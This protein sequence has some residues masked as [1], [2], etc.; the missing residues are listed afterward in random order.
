MQ[1]KELATE[2]SLVALSVWIL[3]LTAY[4]CVSAPWHSFLSSLRPDTNQLISEALKFH[5]VPVFLSRLPYVFYVLI[6]N[7]VALLTG[8]RILRLLKACPEFNSGS[9]DSKIERII[10]SIPL[11]WG[12]YSIGIFYLGI[13]GLLYKE[14]VYLFLTLLGILSI[15]EVKRFFEPHHPIHLPHG[16]SP[17]EADLGEIKVRGFKL[18]KTDLVFLPI[19]IIIIT[20]QFVISF[21]LTPSAVVY[22]M[23]LPKLYIKHHAL[24]H[25]PGFFHST[26]PAH[27]DMLYLLGLITSGETL[28]K[29]FSLSISLM[30]LIALLFVGT[31][32]FSKGAGYLAVVIMML[33]VPS[34]STLFSEPYVDI[35]FG[36]FSLLG[37][38]VFF[39]WVEKRRVRQ[40]HPERSRRDGYLYLAIIY[41]AL[42]AATKTPGLF[43]VLLFFAGFLVFVKK[44]RQFLK[45]LVRCILLMGIT[46]LPWYIRSWWLT[47]DPVF[48]S[49][50]NYLG[51]RYWNEYS[52]N[53]FW[54]YLSL[55]EFGGVKGFSDFI[56]INKALFSSS[57]QDI[58]NSLSP[59]II[60]FLMPALITLRN[61]NR[62][63][64]YFFFITLGYYIFFIFTS[65]QSRFFY[66]GLAILGIIVAHFIKTV[67][68][69]YSLIRIPIIL[70]IVA[71]SI[72]SF[73]ASVKWNE[74]SFF[75]G[76]GVLDQRR[77]LNESPHCRVSTW[78][79]E[80]LP[81][82]S[83]ILSWIMWG[84]FMD[85]EYVGVDPARQGVLDFG[86]INDATTFLKSIKELG[87]THLLYDHSVTFERPFTKR[88]KGLLD[89]CVSEL[90]EN[91]KIALMKKID[92]C[93]IYSVAV[94]PNY[95][96]LDDSTIKFY[97]ESQRRYLAIGWSSTEAWGTWSEGKESL[98]ILNF[99]EPKDY[100]MLINATGFSIP[101]K[102][103]SVK[104]YLDDKF[105]GEHT[106][107]HPTTYF[108]S[109]EMKIPSAYIRE[110]NQ[111]IKFVYGFTG[112]PAEHGMGSDIRQLAMG[113]S[114]IEFK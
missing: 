41:C 21:S 40:A 56:R 77:F 91:G 39:M 103:Q 44:D 13:S 14:A 113:V 105:L 87:I 36:L 25:I 10:F 23:A 47:G 55:P 65:P 96:I 72:T 82:D 43:F 76:L 99:R 88:V 94:A 22:H 11:G 107:T 106:F 83:K 97:D 37:V 93:A 8:N 64:R 29:L 70:C 61:W 33:S 60:I 67:W 62:I 59:I 34:F 84:Y 52:N 19:I 6:L 81:E 75:A 15:L 9:I 86:G 4:Y 108:E 42:A 89:R 48:P 50:Y 31:K 3:S 17:P 26:L 63:I 69:K 80:N 58:N 66:A 71:L 1:K 30:F 79:K 49:F 110:G 73:F 109:L 100:I 32:Y 2:V 90:L 51:G 46:A 112:S 35:A 53:C 7:F 101:G 28:S 104:I 95:F 78:I 45:K 74:G 92:N 57:P 27:T 54:E 38:Y 16:E 114:S 24:V 68:T 12:I 5:W 20:Y 102:Q 18:D 85:R 111:R 98:I